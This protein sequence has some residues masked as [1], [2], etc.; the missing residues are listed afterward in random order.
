MLQPN[1]DTQTW[2]WGERLVLYQRRTGRSLQLPIGALERG[3]EALARRLRDLHVLGPP[4][5]LGALIP[6]RSRWPLLFPVERLLWHPLPLARGP[7]GFPFT[8]LPLSPL[9]LEAWRAFNGARR[10]DQVAA[11]LGAPLAALERFVAR[12][13]A[14]EVQALQ[15]RPRPPA[16]ADPSLRRLL[17]PE[18]PLHARAAHQYGP[19]GE[20]TLQRWHEQDIH[21]G[22]TH[23][24]DRE[25]TL[26]H[27]FARP[28]AALQ[29]ESY[30]ARLARRLDEAG[31][32]P[33]PGGSILEIGPGT[34]ELCAALTAALD[35]PRRY[36]RLD[37][38][39][40]LL[41]TQAAR[42]PGTEGLQGSATAIPLP[43]ASV[44]LVL[45]NEVIADLEASPSPGE[46]P[47]RPEPGQRLF[48][49]GAWRMM[50]EVA[51]VLRPGG[52]LFV[53]EFG[54]AE[55]RPVE[56]TQLD[57][58]EVSVHFGQLLEVAR[59]RE[60]DA[61]LHPVAAW[62][63]F[64]L[65]ARWLSRASYEALRARLRAEGRHLQ[66]RAW[67]LDTLDLPWP[68]EGLTEVPIHEDGPGPVATRF[69]GLI[70][71]RAPA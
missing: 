26:A 50:G 63:G 61:E 57:H 28:H 14:P 3:S 24:D 31:L 56:T 64:D 46:A 30:G 44:D 22:A 7:G 67:T 51:R 16:A 69:M 47:I 71:R 36:I 9:E 2:T 10:L 43:D 29:G 39:P 53:T 23:F 33:P 1:A 65:R 27:A 5:A 42:C 11:G 18:R 60:L 52:G 25:T 40:E 6:C 49:T 38:S 66:A 17:A 68:V 19:A 21:D 13:T 4:P 34:G 58:P 32:L 70:G 48:N 41:A 37:L 45:S 15:L 20:T 54:G 8:G 59:A 55:E 62:M 35:A 12:L